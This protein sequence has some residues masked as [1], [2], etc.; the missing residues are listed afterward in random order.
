MVE[1][2]KSEFSAARIESLIR[3]RAAAGARGAHLDVF[4]FEDEVP[5]WWRD[6][7]CHIKAI[8]SELGIDCKTS[9]ASVVPVGSDPIVNH[10]TYEGSAQ[11]EWK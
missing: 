2:K 6:V 11:F 10:T 5:G 4:S 1:A 7:A 8:A 3:D 9:T